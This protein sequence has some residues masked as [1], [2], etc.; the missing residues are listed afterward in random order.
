MPVQ[1]RVAVLLLVGFA[2]TLPGYAAAVVPEKPRKLESAGLLETS[3]SALVRLFER[4]M[5]KI[6]PPDD[7]AAETPTGNSDGDRGATL[8]PWG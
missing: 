7:P 1:S 3:W 4:G 6:A 2:L 5:T 8:D